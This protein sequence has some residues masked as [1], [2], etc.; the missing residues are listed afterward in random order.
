MAENKDSMAFLEDLAEGNLEAL[1][2]LVAVNVASME[3]SGLDAETLMLVRMAVLA[4]IDAPSISWV[5]NLGVAAETEVTLDQVR[6]V[7]VAIAPLVGTARV[8][9]AAGKIRD[10]LFSG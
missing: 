1:S 3:E 6:G 2:F 4:A 5:A 7:L 9:S 10:A 8:M